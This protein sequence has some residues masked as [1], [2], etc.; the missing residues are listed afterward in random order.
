M[1]AALKP[2]F[3]EY[4][5]IIITET[6]NETIKS[7]DDHL[8]Q[9]R[10][11]EV[12]AVAHLEGA[13]GLLSD[14]QIAAKILQRNPWFSGSFYLTVFASIITV[15]AIVQRTVDAWSFPIVLFARV[16]ASILIGAFQLKNDDRL[17][18]KGFLKLVELSSA[19]LLSLIKRFES[20]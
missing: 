3:P 14:R 1:H 19:S 8:T 10:K 4:I 12:D 11:A 6:T 5:N 9:A 18:E 7:L 17:S 13:R 15:I 2:V 16:V 20:R